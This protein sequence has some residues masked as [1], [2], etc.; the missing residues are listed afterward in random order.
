MLDAC[1]PCGS[2]LEQKEMRVETAG[3]G[4]G[5]AQHKTLHL[6]QTKRPLPSLSPFTDEDTGAQKAGHLSEGSMV[7]QGSRPP[8]GPQTPV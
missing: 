8:Q 1:L 4:W 3:M 6:T 5:Q 2:D 7:S